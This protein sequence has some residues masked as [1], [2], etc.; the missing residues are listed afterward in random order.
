MK[1]YRLKSTSEKNFR[2]AFQKSV[3]GRK[4]A[5]QTGLKKIRKS[6]NVGNATISWDKRM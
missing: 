4:A 1:S 6:R 3:S 5:I 2:K